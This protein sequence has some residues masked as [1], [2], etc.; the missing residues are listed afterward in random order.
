M[1]YLDAALDTFPSRKLTI[2]TLEQ[3]VKFVQS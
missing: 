2:D 1:G 3:A